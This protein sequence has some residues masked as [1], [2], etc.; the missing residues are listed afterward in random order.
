MRLLLGVSFRRRR[1]ARETGLT[2]SPWIDD[3]A[4]LLFPSECVE[5][6]QVETCARGASGAGALPVVFASGVH[7]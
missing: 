1:P 2:I 3:D 6:P 7:F 5:S 4:N